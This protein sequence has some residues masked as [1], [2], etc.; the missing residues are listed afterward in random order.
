V[1]GGGI[2]KGIEYKRIYIYINIKDLTPST[3]GV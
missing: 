2:V 3:P 1:S